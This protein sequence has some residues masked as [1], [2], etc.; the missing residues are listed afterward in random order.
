[1]ATM[2]RV[3]ELFHARIRN[4]SPDQ[5]D[6]A[7][8]LWIGLA[9]DFFYL[10]HAEDT[11]DIVVTSIAKQMAKEDGN[12]IPGPVLENLQRLVNPTTLV[13]AA[14]R[15]VFLTAFEPEPNA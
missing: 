10:S 9:L 2:E 5:L 6:K 8:D 4:D 1:M 11:V 3:T 12:T 7:G 13:S 15:L 14:I